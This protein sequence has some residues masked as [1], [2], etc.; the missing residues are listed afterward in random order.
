MELLKSLADKA[1]DLAIIDVPY[2]INEGA[3]QRKNRPSKLWKKANKEIKYAKKVWDS[4]APNEQY[5][6][7]LFRVSKNQIIWGANHFI[8]NIKSA[9]SSAWIFWDKKN[10][11]TYFSDGEL[12]WT[13]FKKGVRKFEYLWNGFQKQHPEDR[14]HPTQKPV[15][16]YKWLLKNYAKEGDK[17]LDTHIGSGSSA[18]ACY[19][20]G[21]DLLACE[22]DKEYFDAMTI[23]FEQHK[24]QQKLIL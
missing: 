10:G 6:N 22:L 5:F 17:I 4:S 14:I 18:I 8:E 19:D 23:R 20:M 24:L 3:K 7:E 16:L 9:N 2:G 13:S 21:F 1:I 12:A 15:A 11:N